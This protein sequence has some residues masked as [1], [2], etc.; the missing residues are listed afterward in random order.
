MARVFQS[1]PGGEN[2]KDGAEVQYEKKIRVGDQVFTY[3]LQSALLEVGATVLLGRG[4]RVFDVFRI[5]VDD[6]V[7]GF[8]CAV[9]DDEKRIV[10]DRVAFKTPWVDADGESPRDILGNLRD[11]VIEN[12]YS[13]EE[14]GRRDELKKK[15]EALEKR[16]APPSPSTG[17]S[18]RRAEV[19]P[20]LDGARRELKDLH[21]KYRKK[22]DE[23]FVAIEHECAT[24][25]RGKDVST[26]STLRRSDAGLDNRVHM[27]D[28]S[29]CYCL[30]G[31]PGDVAASIRLGFK[32]A[33]R[34]YTD[35]RQI[36]TVFKGAGTPL[37]ALDSMADFIKVMIHCY[38]G[39]NSSP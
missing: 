25:R 24:Q 3:R 4:T 29:T 26:R 39:Q 28:H 21:D 18:E 35:K 9:V 12:S 36:D 13:A 2:E 19:Q 10:Q 8:R 32:S 31:Q 34:Q 11:A 1:R 23:H 6:K 15:E 14:R 30:K 17:S 16:L 22:F 38:E 7:E 5:A 27:A 20:E 37:F 33:V